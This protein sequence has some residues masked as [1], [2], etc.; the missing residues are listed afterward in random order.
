[1]IPLGL[2]GLFIAGFIT[3]VQF[4]DRS[5]WLDEA[6]V[7]NSIR[8]ASL[9]QAIY[10][11][12]WL[13]T[14]PPLFIALSRLITA[15]FGTSNA[16]LRALPAF[17]GIIS[18]MLF[19][20]L[21][22]RLLKT[23]ALITTL[24]FVFSPRLIL[25]SQSVKQYSTDVLSTVTLLLLGHL[26]MENHSERWFYLLLAGFVALSFLSYNVMLFLRLSCTPPSYN[27]ICGRK[28]TILQSRS[29]LIGRG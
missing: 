27:L 15:L 29:I 12:D 21:A 18:V 13:Q 25:Y 19:L 2:G 20:F 26:Y 9:H 24:L 4:L 23:S 1:M 11:D 28:R 14:T 10:Y 3:R 5:L 8:A 16:A 22:V 7:A 6:W 17:S